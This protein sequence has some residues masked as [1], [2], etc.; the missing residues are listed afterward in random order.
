MSDVARR[1][2]VPATTLRFYEQQGLL[3][4]G[5]TRAGYRI[6]DGTAL[7]RLGFITTATRLGLALPEIRR[8]L[9]PWEHGVCRDVQAELGPL[10]DTRVVETRAR[11]AELQEFADRL[12]AARLHLATIDRDGPC[13]RSCTFLREPHR[14]HLDALPQAG[15]IACSLGAENREERAGQWRAA[16]RAVTARTAIDDGLRLELDPQESDLVELTR[17]ASA[18]AACCTFLRLTLEFGPP[19]ALE[20][21]APHEAHAVVVDLFGEPTA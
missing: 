2:G 6:Y 4:A 14:P 10:L 17:L 16:L 9:E 20:V 1:S 11:I 7:D 3:P 15:P 8:L 13:D 19:P 12:E 5:R 21:R 18:E